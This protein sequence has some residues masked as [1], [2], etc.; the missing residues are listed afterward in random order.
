MVYMKKILLVEDDVF[1]Q[2]L[3]SDILQQEGY[4]VISSGEG[5]Q[6]LKMIR[7]RT[8]D[9]ILLDIL[10]PNM[11]GFTILATLTKEH[12]RPTC[13][14]VF[15]TN[16]DATESDKQKLSAADDYWTKSSMSPPEFLEKVKKILS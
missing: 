5:T 16:L 1:L 10:L 7:E 8:W 4:Q 6:A 13:P 12:K 15:M 14:V 3:Y 2:Q 11:D 9:L